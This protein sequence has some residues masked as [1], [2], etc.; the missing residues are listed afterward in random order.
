MKRCDGSRQQFGSVVSHR[1]YHDGDAVRPVALVGNL[2]VVGAFA[3]A[4]AAFDGAVDSVVRHVL[5]FGVG[6]RLAQPR[7]RIRVSAATGLRRDR[8]L[9]DHFGEDLATLSVERT[10]FMLDC[11]PLTVS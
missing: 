5:G 2:V 11:V 4:H 1:L 10:F 8:D 3:L 6:Y 7:V 9:L